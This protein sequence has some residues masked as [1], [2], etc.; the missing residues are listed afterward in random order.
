MDTAALW[1]SDDDALAGVLARLV[2]LSGRRVDP[3]VLA[4]ALLDARVARVGTEGTWTD[5]LL[6]ACTRLGLRA[7]VVRG[8]AERLLDTVGEGQPLVV[9]VSRDA[10]ALVTDARGRR[11]RA[12]RLPSGAPTWESRAS[13]FGATAAAQPSLEIEAVALEPEAP[14]GE[15]AVAEDE[16]DHGHLPP[17]PARRVWTFLVAERADV[18]TLVVYAL[19]VG[20]LSLVIPIT[21][22]ALVTTVTF[23]TLT[24]PLVVLSLLV[25]GALAFAATLR[26]LSAWVVEVLQRRVFARVTAAL[27]ARLIH[28]DR[29]A[30]AH[31][32]GAR[33][34][35]RFME[36]FSLQKSLASLLVD[37][38]DVVLTA[39]VG[40][41]VLGFYHPLL[42]GLDVALVAAVAGVLLFLGRRGPPTAIAECIAKYDTVD[43]LEDVAAGSPRRAL[44]AGP[45][46]A[47]AQAEAH[48]RAWLRAREEHFSIVFAQTVSV[49][50]LQAI[51]SAAL[52]GVGGWLVVSRQLTLGQLV[53]AELI[54]T[55][56][57][58]AI[59]KLGK[60]LDTYYD[61][62]A[63]LDKL[64]HVLAIPRESSGTADAP[65]GPLALELEAAAVAGSAPV[66]FSLEASA[67]HV[68]HVRDGDHA[69]ELAA[70]ATTLVAPASGYV[71]VAG[72]DR[73]DLDLA[74]V[75]ERV[76]LCSDEVVA[77]TVLDV[78]RAGR[79]TSIPAVLEA[80]ARVGLDVAGWPGSVRT[81]VGPGGRHLTRGERARLL[82]A[83]ALAARADLVVVD[84]VLDDLDPEVR[85]PLAAALSDEHATV[86]VLTEKPEAVALSPRAAIGGAS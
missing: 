40:M 23:G 19:F 76:E 2:S 54:V 56:V 42:L 21:V 26:G 33:L 71:R 64:D 75:R 18:A 36:V 85:A 66:T 67:K 78:V 14:L 39:L 35:T 28:A 37:G 83:R 32:E 46:L 51:A 41:L 65:P 7:T 10:F 72:I 86:L 45:T 31:G 13:L 77:G 70:L 22:Q 9:P 12:E 63:S 4:E 15:V 24:Q 16:H 48:A 79:A 58:G 25:L 34:A 61:A 1:F 20:L 68:A 43:L 17:S 3:I 55:T 62:I 49:L 5:V 84:R 60:H 80:L 47:A 74:S 53:A 57:V 81:L 50:A 69:A 11:V 27:S 52:L 38:L 30:L 6:G 29:G 59:A 8:P 82:V 44:G 73:R